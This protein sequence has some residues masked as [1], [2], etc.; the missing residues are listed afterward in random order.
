MNIPD[1]LRVRIIAFAWLLLLAMNAQAQ[2]KILFYGPTYN[3]NGKAE[4]LVETSANFYHVNSG[5]IRSEVWTPGNSVASKDWSRKTTAD[6]QAF[7]AIVFS[8]LHLKGGAWVQFDDDPTDWTGAI[9][10]V[11]VWSAAITG[12]VLLFAG[13]PE[14]HADTQ[15]SCGG[16]FPLAGAQEFIENSVTF[17]AAASHGLYLPLSAIDPNLPS[18]V[19]PTRKCVEHLLS[20][21]GS[22][23]VNEVFANKVRKLYQSP[24]LAN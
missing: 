20:G 11:S 22:F 8:D 4:T 5:T 18:P 7:D 21:L 13:D 23:S 10:N 2:K 12:N 1:T 3:P 9:A 17:A 16:S 19:S 14:A 24:I 6:F 15:C